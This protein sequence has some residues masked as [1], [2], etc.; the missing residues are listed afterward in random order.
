MPHEAILE[1][2]SRIP[3]ALADLFS[4]L[5]AG[6]DLSAPRQVLGTLLVPPGL[7]LLLLATGLLLAFRVLPRTGRAIAWL[8]FVGLWF[9]SSG[10]GAGWLASLAEAG[11]VQGLSL[12]ALDG[13][14]RSPSRPQAI[15]VI[16]GGAQH[17][18]GESPEPQ[19]VRPLTLERLVHA[20]WIARSTRLP[21]MVS[22]GPP[23]TGRASEASLMK[24]TLEQA[25]A[26][27]VRWTEEVSRDTGENAMF[28]ARILREAGVERVILVTQAY[29]MPRAEASF[30]RAGLSVLPAPHGFAGSQPGWQ[31][32]DLLPN[33]NAAALSYRASHELLGR[34]WYRIRGR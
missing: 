19:T 24:R 34:V 6:F 28:S 11:H 22:G 15:V 12:D 20:A 27:P 29:H 3:V 10:L 7:L 14:M 1:W 21:V 5:A 8:A 33:G 18:A 13:A 16:G 2:L 9:T 25:L 30:R 17:H 31:L 4:L 23:R 26:T 32:S